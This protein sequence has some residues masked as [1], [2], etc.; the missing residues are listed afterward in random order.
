[1]LCYY[2][3]VSPCQPPLPFNVTLSDFLYPS[4]CSACDGEITHTVF[5]WHDRSNMNLMNM[6]WTEKQWRNLSLSIFLSVLFSTLGVNVNK[7]Q[8]GIIATTHPVY[9]PSSFSQWMISCWQAKGYYHGFR[10]KRNA[11]ALHNRC[12]F[13]SSQ[14]PPTEMR[15]KRYHCT[16]LTQSVDV[17][18]LP[19][20]GNVQR[21]HTWT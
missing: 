12:L 8:H 16:Q 17:C 7:C 5:F 18:N 3:P 15:R 6:F 11:T 1:M 19:M 9:Q 10:S 20:K 4:L 2:Q 13:K 21:L 14:K